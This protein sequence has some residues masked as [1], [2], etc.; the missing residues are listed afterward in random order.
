MHLIFQPPTTEP[1]RNTVQFAGLE[2][3]DLR[4]DGGYIVVAPSRHPN[5]QQYCWLSLIPPA[6]FPDLLVDLLEQ[7]ERLQ[8]LE[9]A[10]RQPASIPCQ[11]SRSSKVRRPSDPNF[12]LQ[13]A[14]QL[15]R[16]G[17]RHTYALWLACR[18]IEHVGLTPQEAEPYVRQYV[19]LVPGGNEDY[20]LADALNCLQ[21]AAT[22]VITPITT[23]SPHP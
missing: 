1:L 22:H 4:G 17:T 5:G 15:A 8:R 11:H 9:T 20:P 16:V 14:V 19:D 3:I 6:P 23:T 13:K 12:W 2:G 21:W 10:H 7:Q 18:L